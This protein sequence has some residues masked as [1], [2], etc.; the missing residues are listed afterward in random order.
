M[1]RRE[2]MRTVRKSFAQVGVLGI[3]IATACSSS[4]GGNPDTSPGSGD[5]GT[6]GDATAATYPASDS[7]SKCQATVTQGGLNGK[8]AGTTCE[9]LGI[10]YGA[11]PTDAL[12]F[13]PPQPAAAWSSAR[14][15]TTFGASCMQAGAGLGSV[16]N[17]S[18]DCLFVNVFT[19]QAAPTKPL[20][21]MVFIYGGAFTT[22]S[23][24]TYDTQPL[25]E[26]GPAIVVTMNYRLGA[27]GFLALPDLDAERSGAPSGSDGIRD[28][29]LALKWV[30]DNIATFHGDADNV[31]VFGESAGATSACIHIVSPG[32]QGLAN[33]FI[34]E[35]STCVGS[36]AQLNTQA[37]SY[38]VG[39]ELAASFCQSDAG[40][41]DGGAVLAGADLVSC[42]R[43]A[44]PT[45][46]MTWLP[47][48]NA[49]GVGVTAGLG[50]LLGPPFAPTIGGGTGSVL[51]DTPSKLIASGSFDKNAQV[52]GGTNANEWGLFVA[53][54]SNPAYGGSA[55]SP[56]NVMTAAQLNVIIAAQFGS[57]AAQVEAQYPATDATAR[58]V[59]IDMI[60]DNSFRCPMRET[61]RQMTAQGAKSYL[62]AY[63]VGPAWHAFELVP[64]F[65]ITALSQLGAATP[66]AAVTDDMLGYWT[67]FAA[68]GDPNG[69]GDAGAP[70]WPV[71]TT[72]NDETLELLEP[73]PMAT[74][75]LKGT[76]CDFWASLGPSTA[77]PADAGGE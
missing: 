8:L 44:D 50:N 67:S 22:G 24:T 30:H 28:Q 55:S 16:G 76:Q 65:T 62:Y 70:T 21:V 39:S 32:S 46:L 33:R 56:L 74:A 36:T 14:D 19:P 5:G 25:S 3:L 66:S 1:T 51:P 60:T 10:P 58:Q 35:S 2:S 40:A 29:Q 26:K 7:T 23:S 41:G 52:L 68:T 64:L 54:A 75:R 45:K 37:D 38:L 34:L 47:P 27:L 6:T 17:T 72:A 15:A 42:L 53:L 73:T 69:S 43:T 61:A 57:N 9:Y 77:A 71:N 59:F 31:T 63:E 4:S 12:R 18:E 20:P 13:M 11:P 49:P 48:A